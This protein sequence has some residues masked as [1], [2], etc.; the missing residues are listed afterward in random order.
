MIR[1][2]FNN[3]P[4]SDQWLCQV[5]DPHESLGNNP[6]STVEFHSGDRYCTSTLGIKILCGLLVKTSESFMSIMDFK[7]TYS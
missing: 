2:Q 5:N 7:R 4:P 3:L 1:D 6:P